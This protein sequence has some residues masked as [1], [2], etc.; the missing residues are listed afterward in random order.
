M[1]H[2]DAVQSRRPS[3]PPPPARVQATLAAMD[4]AQVRAAVGRELRSHRPP[5]RSPDPWDP[6]WP[7]AT[8]PEDVCCGFG[9]YR[10]QQLISLSAF[11]CSVYG[12][13]VR[14]DPPHPYRGAAPDLSLSIAVGFGT[15]HVATLAAGGHRFFVV[16]G[17]EVQLATNRGAS[18]HP[19]PWQG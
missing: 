2:P 16:G 17:A 10:R 5:A 19:L 15:A 13:V 14:P 9:A 7:L 4:M 3:P 6:C 1:A 18:V 12:S 8:V 11:A